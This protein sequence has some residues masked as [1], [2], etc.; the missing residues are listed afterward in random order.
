MK[1]TR[2]NIH[3][4]PPY[5]RLQ[6]Q[7]QQR[8]EAA[9]QAAKMSSLAQGFASIQTNTVREQGNLISQIAMS[10]MSKRV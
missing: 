9:E 8:A 2:F 3:Q 7:R 1:I 6:L 4:L 10:R 5:E